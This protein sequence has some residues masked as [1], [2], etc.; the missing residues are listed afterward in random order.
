MKN[1]FHESSSSKSKTLSEN[2]NTSLNTY[3]CFSC[4]HHICSTCLD[5]SSK[6]KRHLYKCHICPRSFHLNC[7]PPD[8]HFHEYCLICPTCTSEGHI[9]PPLYLDHNQKNS[10]LNNKKWLNNKNGYKSSSEK[11]EPEKILF[12]LKSLNYATNQSIQLSDINKNKY[13]N[14]H[15]RLDLSILK[16]VESRPPIFTTI[17]MNQYGNIPITKI[18]NSGNCSCHKKPL[19]YAS[20]EGGEGG[21]KVMK[22]GTRAGLKAELASILPRTCGDDCENR[23][24]RIECIGNDN[25]DAKGAEK[26]KNKG[27]NCCVGETCG[28]RQISLKKTVKVIKEFSTFI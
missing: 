20:E 17:S 27:K 23:L 25:D 19:Q 14:K 26:M 24:L 1:L 28:N 2:D 5:T 15:F 7:I 4:A 13:D 18:E 16:E 12:H 10:N 3:Q 6:G 22:K 11:P 8:S 21:E 9:L